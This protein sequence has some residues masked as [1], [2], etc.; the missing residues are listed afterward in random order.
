MKN[1]L[2]LTGLVSI[3][4]YAWD[5]DHSRDVDTTLDLSGSASLSVYTGAGDL[6][7]R[8]QSG[9]S[10]A[11]ITGKIC[12]SEKEWLVDTNVLVEDGREAS[13]STQIPDLDDG[14]SGWG[15]RYAY[16]DLLIEVPNNVPLEVRDSSGDI[17]IESTAAVNVKDS[18]GEIVIEDIA[19]DVVL[20]D[21]SGDIDL[22]DIRGNV[23]VESD[24]SGDIYGRDIEGNVVVERDSSGDIRFRDVR[25]DFVVERD[26][27]GDIVA[28]S[29]G[30]DFRV[31]RDGSGDI[32]SRN[33]SGAVDVPKKG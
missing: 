6:E 28:D 24:S 26:S 33:V 16:I 29:V 17:R 14:W 10:Q 7:I 18:S 22:E 12:V 25:D 19:G 9:T 27:S 1:V 8:G 31:V 30:G 3:N 21:S 5:C 13:I 2:L 20:N 23:T 4:G 15:S 32:E 11:R